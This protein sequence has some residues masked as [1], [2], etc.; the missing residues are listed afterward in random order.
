LRIELKPETIEQIESITGK[1][2][3][4]RCDRLVK[5]ALDIA[6][7]NPV[8]NDDSVPQVKLTPG[9]LEVLEDA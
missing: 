9:I 8:E 3:T 7:D 2:M 6:T 1:K 5:E 4:T